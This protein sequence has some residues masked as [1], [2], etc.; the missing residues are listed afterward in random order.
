[1]KFMFFNNKIT[2][3][4]FALVICLLAFTSCED[5]SPNLINDEYLD[6]P[7]KHF[8]TMLIEQGID[9]DS[10]VNQQMLKEDAEE[11]THLDLNLSSHFGEIADL[12]GIEGFVNLKFLS[13]SNQEL[14]HVD[15]SHNT[16]LDTIYLLGNRLS[17]IDFSNNPSLVFVDLQANEFSSDNSIIGLS[18]ATNLKDL[19]ISW[20]YLEEF[21]I[22]NKSLEVLH[23]SH[24]DLI[25]LDTDG[26]INLQ[27][28]LL[29]SNK[30]EMVD[31]STNRLLETLLISDNKLEEID[32]ENNTSLTHLYSS[33][34]LLT[35]LDVSN[36]QQLIDLRI[37]RN[38]YLTCIKILASQEI[39]TV[40][41][42]EYQELNN[43]CL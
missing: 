43:E 2:C 26:A 25:S 32:L 20:N 31:F 15:L 14:T 1:M 39:P 41:I 37:D 40:S 8:E 6:I 35:S 33:S 19:D 7:D 13:A 24:N 17:S 3:L 11:V 23:M 12:A 21:S 10:I 27:H 36:N 28:V 42:S 18:N 16:L 30:L 4:T 22:H 34:N 5:E 9:S 38:P 29:T